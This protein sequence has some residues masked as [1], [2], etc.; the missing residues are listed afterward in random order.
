MSRGTFSKEPLTGG[1]IFARA[2]IISNLPQI[3][4]F[5]C[6]VHGFQ[7]SDFKLIGFGDFPLF[8]R[9]SVPQV[10]IHINTGTNR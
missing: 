9:I 6:T 2:S 7:K 8:I 1:G 5:T 3:Y 4:K 10:M